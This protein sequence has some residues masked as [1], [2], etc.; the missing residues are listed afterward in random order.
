LQNSSSRNVVQPV[1]IVGY[2]PGITEG[3]LL[4]CKGEWKRNGKWGEQFAVETFESLMPTTEIGIVR[5]LS[6]GMVSGI[7]KT[8]A[9]RIVRKF[10]RNT[11][12]VLDNEPQN[13][14]KSK[15]LVPNGSST[16]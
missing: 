13:F 4:R 6:S 12:D 11:L 10:G 2:I 7:G 15:E 8:F 1:T 3:E 9:E 16:S 5:Y 14:A